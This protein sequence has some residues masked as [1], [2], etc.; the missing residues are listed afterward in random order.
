[1]Q[2]PG[3]GKVRT[4]AGGRDFSVCSHLLYEYL[5]CGLLLLSFAARMRGGVHERENEGDKAE[6]CDGQE[7][8]EHQG[9]RNRLDIPL[10]LWSL[11]T[12]FRRR[13]EERRAA[14]K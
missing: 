10:I 3:G 13:K 5:R 7:V 6:R 8:V 9:R 2:S 11:A 4:H 1:M 14:I 12:R